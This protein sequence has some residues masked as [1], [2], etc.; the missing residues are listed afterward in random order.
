MPNKKA[1]SRKYKKRQLNEKWK[2]EGRTAN[3][4]KKWLAKQAEKGTQLP[5]WGRR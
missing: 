1:K 2:K 5:V 4:H 3:Q